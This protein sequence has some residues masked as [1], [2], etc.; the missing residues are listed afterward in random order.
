M[1]MTTREAFE[2]GTE[3]FNAHDRLLLLEQL[4]LTPAPAG[5]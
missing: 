5:S 1:T 2:Q 3:T 4:G